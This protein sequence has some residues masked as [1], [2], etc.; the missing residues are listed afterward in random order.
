MLGNVEA[1]TFP[2]G[3]YIVTTQWEDHR[4]GMT[5][6]WVTR[7]SAAPAMIAMALHRGSATREMIG[8]SGWFVVHAL[9]ES[10]LELAR[11][12]G[13]GTS[14]ERDKFAGLAPVA[15]AHGQ[16]ILVQAKSFLECQVVRREDVGDHEL[17]VGLVVDEKE[18]RVGEPLRYREDWFDQ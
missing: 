9:P 7:V 10:G 5:A 14:T 2:K 13:R 6:A 11:S 16:P 15:S 3:V 18:L 1:R 4:A 8:R 17:I 12:F